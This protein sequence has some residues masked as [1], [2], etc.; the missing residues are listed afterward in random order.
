MLTR[1]RQSSNFNRSWLCLDFEDDNTIHSNEISDMIRLKD[2]FTNDIIS[3]M[4]S[5]I[6]EI[7]LTR[8]ALAGSMPPA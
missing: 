7:G 8:L 5:G 4:T 1:G 6:G 2:V 3:S